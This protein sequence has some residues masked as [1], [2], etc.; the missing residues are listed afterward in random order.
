[1]DNAFF[2]I[3]PGAGENGKDRRFDL[4]DDDVGVETFLY[5][6]ILFHQFADPDL[7]ADFVLIDETVVKPVKRFFSLSLE[8]H[9]VDDVNVFIEVINREQADVV[10]P[11]REIGNKFSAHMAVD[12]D[13]NQIDQN[14]Q[15]QRADGDEGPV[16]IPV[17]LK[18]IEESNHEN[19]LLSFIRIL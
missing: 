8:V 15:S 1:M 3:D 19:R 13:V 10:F 18:K 6:M 14:E 12:D 16:F 9:F 11:M 17:D 7:D 5:L 2:V 4:P